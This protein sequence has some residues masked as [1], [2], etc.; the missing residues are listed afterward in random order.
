MKMNSF[1][2]NSEYHM[3]TYQEKIMQ[4]VIRQFDGVSK[5]DAYDI[6]HKIESL[7]I[8]F[9]TPIQ[10]KEIKK[11]ILSTAEI[12][13]IKDSGYCYLE[14]ECQYL[15]VYNLKSLFPSLFGIENLYFTLPCQYELIAF[16]NRNI[17]EV[18]SNTHLKAVIK[19]FL[20][21]NHVR[22]RNPKTKRLLLLELLD[23]IDPK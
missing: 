1:N 21:K 9:S 10:C 18:F 16:D 8:D 4:N 13:P 2:N 3:I 7:L 22:K 17:E 5:L 12:T 20:K 11:S 6:L 19:H 14:D 15:S 23:T